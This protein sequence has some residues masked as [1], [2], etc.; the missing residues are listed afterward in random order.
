MNWYAHPESWSFILRRY[1]PRLALCS[2]VWEIVQLPLYTLWAAPRV[3]W[4][5]FAVAHCTV[6]DVMIG[7]TVLILAMILS[8]AGEPV[9]WPRTKLNVI[10]VVLAVTYSLLSERVNLASGSWAYSAWMP[11]LPVIEVGLAPLLQ[12]VIVPIATWWWANRQPPA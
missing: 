7:A 10:T 2:L 11:V 1:L 12:W 4:I 6:G 3:G 5:A 8:G 9:N